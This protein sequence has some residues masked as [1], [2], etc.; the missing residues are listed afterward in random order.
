M[1][2]IRPRKPPPRKV[3]RSLEEPRNI[4]LY[5]D[6]VRNTTSFDL[7][8]LCLLLFF[9]FYICYYYPNTK[10]LPVHVNFTPPDHCGFV[11]KVYW[12][13]SLSYHYKLMR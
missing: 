2:V 13:I 9:I 3:R 8:T 5:C 11:G 12:R 1:V 10:D 6:D 7:I 4:W